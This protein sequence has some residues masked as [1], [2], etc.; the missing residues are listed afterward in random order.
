MDLNHRDINLHVNHQKSIPNLYCV[1]E[2]CLIR[3]SFQTLP[4]K[5][6]KYANLN[7]PITFLKYNFVI[8]IT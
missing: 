1:H 4:S 6:I 7:N 3:S 5:L 2:D 8:G